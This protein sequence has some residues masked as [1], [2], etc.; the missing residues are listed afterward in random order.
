MRSFVRMTWD[1]ITNV[2]LK[3]D[4]LCDEKRGVYAVRSER[5]DIPIATPVVIFLADPYDRTAS[6]PAVCGEVNVCTKTLATQVALRSR[7]W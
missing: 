6:R 4:G 2:P 3:L 1:D 7:V 5:S